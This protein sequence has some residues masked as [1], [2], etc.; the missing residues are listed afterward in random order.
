MCLSGKI[1]N[2]RVISWFLSSYIYTAVFSAL[3]WPLS[4][5][6]RV[7]CSSWRTASHPFHLMMHWC[8]P[9]WIRSLHWGQ[10]YASI[11][12]KH[13]HTHIHTHGHMHTLSHSHTHVETVLQ[14]SRGQRHKDHNLGKWTWNEKP[15]STWF[16]LF[17][18]WGMRT[19]LSVFY[20]HHHV[21]WNQERSWR[22]WFWSFF[23]RSAVQ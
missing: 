22:T 18:F 19:Q 2:F 21:R 1:I 16:L 23:F 20:H 3:T 15:G 12:S 14:S 9:R 10:E 17:M 4:V 13:K 6:D 11:P 7:P 8:G 5:I